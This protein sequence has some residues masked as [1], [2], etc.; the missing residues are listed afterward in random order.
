MTFPWC[1]L[2]TRKVPLTRHFVLW[3]GV[4]GGEVLRRVVIPDFC[5]RMMPHGRVLRLFDELICSRQMESVS[6]SNEKPKLRISVAPTYLDQ[7]YLLNL[8]RM[9]LVSVTNYSPTMC[10]A[11][12]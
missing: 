9:F 11:L 4:E 1:L 2:T 10:H 6:L 12:S 5:I 7:F 8:L 3:C